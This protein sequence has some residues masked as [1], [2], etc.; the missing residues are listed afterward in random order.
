[1][2]FRMSTHS[3]SLMVVFD[4]YFELFMCCCLWTFLSLSVF[5]ALSIDFVS[6]P[7]LGKA[8][9]GGSLNNIDAG[10]IDVAG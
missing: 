9:F 4:L 1:M 6:T 10:G 5:C 7:T 2:K 8:V 3:P